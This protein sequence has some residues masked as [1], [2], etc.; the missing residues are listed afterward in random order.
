MDAPLFIKR[1]GLAAVDHNRPSATVFLKLPIT[2]VQGTDL[3]SFEPA[4]YAVKVECVL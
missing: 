2:I 3:A 1:R 4:G